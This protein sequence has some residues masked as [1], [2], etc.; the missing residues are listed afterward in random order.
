MC[1]KDY[2]RGGR[3]LEGMIVMEGGGNRSFLSFL[4]SESLSRMHK[5]SAFERKKAS[6]SRLLSFP[7]LPLVIL[8]SRQV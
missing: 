3:A 1:T 2:V 7:F 8:V 5:P 4:P 6:N